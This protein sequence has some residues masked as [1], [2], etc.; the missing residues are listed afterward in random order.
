MYDIYKESCGLYDVTKDSCMSFIAKFNDYV[1]VNPESSESDYYK[2]TK[3][4][5]YNAEIHFNI[6]THGWGETIIWEF[7]INEGNRTK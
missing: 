5:I 6:D 4:N 7:T 3:E 2:P 1:L